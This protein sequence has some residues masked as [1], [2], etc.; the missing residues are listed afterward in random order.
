M[1]QTIRSATAGITAFL[2]IFALS[3]NAFAASPP[4]PKSP[5]KNG[6]TVIIDVVSQ[7]IDVSATT[8]YE[9]FRFEPDYLK[10]K[11]GT[12]VRF[13]GSVGRHTVTSVAGMYPKGA[14]PFEIRGKPTMDIPF[15]KEGVYGIRCR[16]HGRHGM[17]MLIVV[18]DPRVNLEKARSAKVGKKERVKFQR[19]FKRLEEDMAAGKL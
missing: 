2:A 1:I 15:N 18:G 3:A 14:R 11:P 19:L 6:E 4:I 12:I 8:S 10:L 16:I 5:P 7:I 9:A 13:Q 17:A